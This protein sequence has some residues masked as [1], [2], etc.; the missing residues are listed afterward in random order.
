MDS[1]NMNNTPTNRYDLKELGFTFQDVSLTADWLHVH[2]DVKVVRSS[3]SMLQRPLLHMEHLYPI[4]LLPDTKSR[5]KWC[6]A[7][8]HISRFEPI[9]RKYLHG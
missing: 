8:G 1:V 9:V 5:I 4:I 3:V 6:V 2:I 7:E